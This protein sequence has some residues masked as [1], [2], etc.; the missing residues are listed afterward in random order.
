MTKTKDFMGRKFK[1]INEMVSRHIDDVSYENGTLERL[2]TEAMNMQSIIS[3][4]CFILVE[5]EI[6]SEEEIVEY[7]LSGLFA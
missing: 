6:L 5:K 1:N 4:L 7:V 3:M 2:Q